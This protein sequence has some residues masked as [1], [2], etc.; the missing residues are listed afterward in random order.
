MN[1]CSF[2]VGDSYSTVCYMSQQNLK[3]FPAGES[4]DKWIARIYN[5]EY[6]RLKGYALKS[7]SNEHDAEDIVGN[8]FAKLA[9]IIEKKPAKLESY[10][11]AKAYLATIIRNACIDYLRKSGRVKELSPSDETI[12]DDQLLV[13]ELE[14]H[15][16]W[17]HLLTLIEHLPTQLRGVIKLS[18][19]EG[20]TIEEISQRLNLS[21]EV[22]YVYKSKAIKRLRELL[23]QQPPPPPS[24]DPTQPPATP[25]PTPSPGHPPAPPAGEDT[26][27]FKSLF[28]TLKKN[29]FKSLL[30]KWSVIRIVN[31]I[32]TALKPYKWKTFNQAWY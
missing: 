5:E 13:T 7:I 30:R 23:R 22:V 8:A 14:E 6:I 17:K 16:L 21:K 20:L 24:G 18:F 26:I 11:H 29:I 2:L 31:S 1:D 27:A 4:D 9:G 19:K 10:T 15:D 3:P 28:S 25:A 12:A 32:T